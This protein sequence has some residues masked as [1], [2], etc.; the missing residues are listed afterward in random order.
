MADCMLDLE[1]LSTHPDAVVL[2]FGAVK[3]DPYSQTINESLSLYLRIDVDEQIAL[4]RHVDD[5][6]IEWWGNQ[7]PEVRNEALGDQ[8]R[9]SLDEFTNKLNKFLVGVKNIWAQGPVF[10][11]VILEN[12]YKQI[13]KPAPWFYW[14]IRDSR[15]LFGVHG[16]PRAK[17]RAGLHNA[18]SD[19]VYQANGVQEIYAK[20]N[21]KKE[22]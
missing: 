13:G 10:D 9:V 22:W 16:D 7:A 21:I 18:L 14:Q 5:G 3:F 11:I 6:T 19:C 1:T 15:T 12:L 2:T 4:D 17:G 20:Y 8:D